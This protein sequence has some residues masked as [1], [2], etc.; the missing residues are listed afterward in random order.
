MFTAGGVTDSKIE[1]CCVELGTGR[2]YFIR[3]ALMAAIDPHTLRLPWKP[4]TPNPFPRRKRSESFSVAVRVDAK[5]TAMWVVQ[6]AHPSGR[7][8]QGKCFHRGG[9]VRAAVRALIR[10]LRSS[11]TSD[12]MTGK[13]NRERLARIRTEREMDRKRVNQWSET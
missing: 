3:R 7:C 11:R 10:R 6:R 9:P 5:T 8:D 4:D 13:I 12:S 1:R 2:A